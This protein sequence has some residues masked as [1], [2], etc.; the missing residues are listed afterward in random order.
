ML[1]SDEFANIAPYN[2]AFAETMTFV[3]DFWNVPVFGEL[4]VVSQ[5]ELGEYIVG[6]E[7]T[8]EEAMNAIAEEHQRILEDA[9]LISP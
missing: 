2:P 6:G 5:N 8:A 4:L 9:D 3:K 1:A 7:G